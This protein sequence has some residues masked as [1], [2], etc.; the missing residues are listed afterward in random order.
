MGHLRLV[1]TAPP[2]PTPENACVRAFDRE[3]D[4]IFATLRRLGAAA[5]DVE[6]L[7]QEVFV[8]LHRNWHSIDLTRPLRPYLFGISFRIV[9]AHRRRRAREIPFADLEGNDDGPGPESALQSKQAMAQLLTALETLPLSRRAVVI[10]HDL[11]EVP[12]AD[13]AR[14]LSIT[15]FGAYARLTKGRRE[16]AAA[17]RRLPRGRTHL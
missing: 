14:C 13:I 4:Y 1:S 10:M 2:L 9:C 15:R 8:V 11:D 16:L 6:D 3:L 7:A 17:V 12:I 5:H